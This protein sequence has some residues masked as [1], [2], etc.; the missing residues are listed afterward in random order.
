MST[1]KIINHRFTSI[2]DVSK[3]VL[4]SIKFAIN[5]T[6]LTISKKLDE[7]LTVTIMNQV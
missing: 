2:T 5:H 6:H 3:I 7:A 1:E 4:I